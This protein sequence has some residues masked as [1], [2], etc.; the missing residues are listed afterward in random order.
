MK[1]LHWQKNI[2]L[3]CEFCF[4]E[5]TLKKVFCFTNFNLFWPLGFQPFYSIFIWFWNTKTLF[6]ISHCCDLQGYK[7]IPSFS[8][9]PLVIQFVLHDVTVRAPYAKFMLKWIYLFYRFFETQTKLQMDIRKI[10]R[11]VLGLL[12]LNWILMLRFV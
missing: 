2:S 6:R 8:Y 10:F 11:F 4:R 9:L 12:T 7:K 3:F 5:Q 1:N